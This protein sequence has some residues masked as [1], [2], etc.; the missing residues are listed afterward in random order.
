MHLPLRSKIITTIALMVCSGCHHSNRQALPI[1]RLNVDTWIGYAPFWLAIDKGIFQSEGVEV[2]ITTMPDVGQ[3]KASILKGS[4]DGIAETVDM[5]VLDQDER[6]PSVCVMQVDVSN[7]ADGILATDT[8][9]EVEDLRGRRIAVQRNYASEAL[10]NYV[11]QKHHLKPSDVQKLD[12]EGGAAG[13]AF[14]SRQV[15]VAV[16]FEPWLSKARQRRGGRVLISSADVPGVIVDVLSIR[17]HFLEGHP[18][19][20]QKVI[21]GWFKALDYW[22]TNPHDAA[23][24]MAKH[25][26][27]T[28]DEFAMLVS[29]LIW[30]SREENIKYFGTRQQQPG[31]IYDIGRTF[32]DIFLET[33]QIRGRPDLNTAID[34]RLL[35]SLDR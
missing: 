22:R 32:V 26:T 1:F 33:G 10:L 8:F 24:K 3:R 30:P 13:A 12:M 25:Y 27:S 19:T 31:P 21:R 11:L 4:T 7:G 23:T 15:D 14:I 29:G 17:R 34:D 28:P 20:V 18:D 2:Q 5:L 6:I 16:T 35:N 9:K